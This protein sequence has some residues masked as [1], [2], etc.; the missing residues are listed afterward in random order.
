[1]TPSTNEV[2]DLVVR[3]ISS[4][5]PTSADERDEWFAAFGLPDGD[6]AVSEGKYPRDVSMPG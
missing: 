5:W 2:F 1:M 4:D 6:W 3:L